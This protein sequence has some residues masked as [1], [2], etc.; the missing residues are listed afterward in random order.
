[1]LWSM[2]A[3]DGRGGDLSV[4][5]KP[6]FFDPT[7]RRWVGFVATTLA[8]L[9]AAAIV[10]AVLS[11]SIYQGAAPIEVSLEDR[12]P[13]P[14]AITPRPAEEPVAPRELSLARVP[15]AEPEARPPES[16]P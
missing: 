6:V 13:E 10:F 1:E 4:S 9:V 3:P 12:L 5:V 16:V 14:A 15:V 7:R 11:V 8:A 2:F